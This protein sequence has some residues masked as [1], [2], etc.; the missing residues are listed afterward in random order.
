MSIM[1]W[2]EL[3]EVCDR[4]GVEVSY[5]PERRSYKFYSWRQEYPYVSV[6]GYLE[7]ELLGMMAYGE[8]ERIVVGYALHGMES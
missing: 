6:Y 2:K 3:R 1:E 4:Y 8:L 7:V 5:D